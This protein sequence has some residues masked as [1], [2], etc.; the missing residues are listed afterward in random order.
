LYI[1]SSYSEVSIGISVNAASTP[2]SM[3][4]GLVL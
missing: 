1:A 4:C 3:D 2:G